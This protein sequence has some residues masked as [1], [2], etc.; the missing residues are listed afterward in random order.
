MPKV[1]VRTLS[2]LIDAKKLRIEGHISGPKAT[3][4]MPIDLHAFCLPEFE[5]EVIAALKRGNI[6]PMAYRALQNPSGVVM[7]HNVAEEAWAKLLRSGQKL[8][9]E[10][11]HSILSDLGLPARHL[12]K[13]KL[14]PQ[15]ESLLTQ[16][17]PYQRQG[18]FW[19]LQAE[20]P[21]IPTKPNETTQFWTFKNEYYGNKSYY[22][23]VATGFGQAQLPEFMRG[24]EFKVKA[25]I[26][27]RTRGCED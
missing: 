1:I 20:H 6:A 26:M 27:T 15:P 2:P 22:Y 25:R 18:L 23:N 9:P 4:D 14:A 24:G 13:L 19:M 11:A 10:A 16:L 5:K 12:E 8:D 3:Y 7:G 17:L 21:H